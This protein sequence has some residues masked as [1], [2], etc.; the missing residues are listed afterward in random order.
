MG[1]EAGYRAL[2]SAYLREN[3]GHIWGLIKARPYMRA[4]FGVALTFWDLDNKKE[5][6]SH[7]WDLLE[8][9]TSD[10]QGVRYILINFLLETKNR[11]DVE[12][13]LKFMPDD[14]SIMW[15]YPKALSIF[16]K[17]GS[18]KK[19]NKALS[20]ALKSNLYVP[21]YLFEKKKIPKKRPDHYA[22]GPKEEAILYVAEGLKS[23]QVIDGAIEWLNNN[24]QS[25]KS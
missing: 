24:V 15:L 3:K 20:A 19:A 7:C 11:A 22:W 12:K 23:W 18:S 9:N 1:L 25:M 16:Q 2:G 4:K 6:I 10:N 5:A 21:D 8:L 17:E 14:G 13:L